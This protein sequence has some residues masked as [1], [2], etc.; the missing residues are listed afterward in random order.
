MSHLL[1]PR[2]IPPVCKIIHKRLLPK[3]NVACE[4]YV[5]TCVCHSVHRGVC[6]IVCWDTTPP[7]KADPPSPTGRA[8]PPSPLWQGRPLPTQCMLGDTVNK[9]AVCILLECNL[10]ENRTTKACYMKGSPSSDI[11]GKLQWKP[12]DLMQEGRQSP[13]KRR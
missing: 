10:V 4:G 11:V 13:K 5:F 8:D 9:R 2:E 7:G 1:R 3:A 6:P 12:R